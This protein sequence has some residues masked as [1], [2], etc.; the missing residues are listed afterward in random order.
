MYNWADA[1]PLLLNVTFSNNIATVD[2]GA[3]RNAENSFPTLQNTIIWGNATESGDGNEI[4]NHSDA[5]IVLNYCLFQD[6]NGDIISGGGFSV[7]NSLNVDP[8][9][10]DSG[11]GN[12][13]LTEGSFAI[14][15]GDP[16]TEMSLF[17]G[18]PDNPIDLDGSPRLIDGR[19]DIGAYENQEN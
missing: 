6:G 15:A 11:S 10:I 2:G 19:I 4:A 8:L 1:F 3:I 13:R 5:S 9:F 17:P 12:L 18:G 7:K 16:D 14:G